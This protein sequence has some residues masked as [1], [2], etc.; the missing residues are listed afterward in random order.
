MKHETTG[1]TTLNPRIEV[2]E[3]M[4][5]PAVA[6]TI[7]LVAQTAP[8]TYQGRLEE[9]GTPGINYAVQASGGLSPANWTGIVTNSPTNGTFTY[10][11]TSASTQTR[12]YRAVKQQ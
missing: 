1:E 10:T 4:V 7:R 5:L 12:F 6:T 3:V 8:V 11:D 9:N 2:A